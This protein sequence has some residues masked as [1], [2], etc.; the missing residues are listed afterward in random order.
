MLLHEACV[1]AV[2]FNEEIGLGAISKTGA[3]THG[4]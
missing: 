1:N 4:L 2:V 3:F